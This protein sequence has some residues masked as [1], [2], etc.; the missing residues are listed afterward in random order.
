MAISLICRDASRGGMGLDQIALFLKLDHLI[1]NSGRAH[2][3]ALLSHDIR[4]H[5]HAFGDIFSDD[6][7]EDSIPSSSEHLFAPFISTLD[8][9][10]LMLK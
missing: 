2:A 4:A 6:D 3:Q 10:V 9:R 1:A 8:V 5:G 7:A